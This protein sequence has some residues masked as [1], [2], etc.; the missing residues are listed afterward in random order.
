MAQKVRMKLFERMKNGKR[1]HL[2][3]FHGVGKSKKAA[4]AHVRRIANAYLR[5]NIVAGFY[6]ATGFH[7][8]RASADYSAGRAGEKHRAG[9]HGLT[10]GKQTRSRRSGKAKR[11]GALYSSHF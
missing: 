6:D 3:T 10:K 8:I 11:S 5:K 2:I 1:R 9:G 4:K 7:P